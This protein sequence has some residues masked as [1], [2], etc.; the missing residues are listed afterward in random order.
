VNIEDFKDYF[1]LIRNLPT[2]FAVIVE[3]YIS[4][5]KSEGVWYSYGFCYIT[6]SFLDHILIEGYK[7]KSE[8]EIDIRKEENK[9]IDLLHLQL[10]GIFSELGIKNIN[11]IFKPVTE[12]KLREGIE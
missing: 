2:E 7:G 10:E 1:F 3:P 8:E 6:N 4:I 9:F 5:K 11:Y 12:Y